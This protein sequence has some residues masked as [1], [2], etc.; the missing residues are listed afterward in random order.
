AIMPFKYEKDRIFNSGISLKRI[1]ENSSC[2]LVFD[3]DALL[4]SNPDLSVKSC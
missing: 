2:T 1:K 3:N 4:D